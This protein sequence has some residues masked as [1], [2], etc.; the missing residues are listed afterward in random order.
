MS[1]NVSL[2]LR[3]SK[4]PVSMFHFEVLEGYGVPRQITLRIGKFEVGEVTVFM[5][6]DQV[7]ALMNETAKALRLLVPPAALSVAEAVLEETV[8]EAAPDEKSVEV[9]GAPAEEEL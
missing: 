7:V 2:H 8:V 4:A 3:N 6:D 9:A 5:R 1:M